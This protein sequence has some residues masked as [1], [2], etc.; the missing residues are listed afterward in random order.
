[1]SIKKPIF[2]LIGSLTFIFLLWFGVSLHINRPLT[3]EES[4]TITKAIIVPQEKGTIKYKNKLYTFILPERSSLFKE[5]ENYQIYLTIAS[6]TSIKNYYYKDL[7]LT[8]WKLKEQLGSGYVLTNG[9]VTF[10]STIQTLARGVN[11]VTFSIH[12]RD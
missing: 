11:K 1:L 2:I 12:Y 9:E 6:S 8:G 7:P 4:K 3:L 5:K 10:T